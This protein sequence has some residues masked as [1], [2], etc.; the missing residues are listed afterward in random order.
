MFKF[1]RNDLYEILRKLFMLKISC[2]PSSSSLVSLLLLQIPPPPPS[3]LTSE[4]VQLQ[5]V[6]K[7]EVGASRLEA[8]RLCLTHLCPCHLTTN[9]LL[10]QTFTSSHTDPKICSLSCFGF[11][12]WRI[13]KKKKKTQNQSSLFLLPVPVTS[14][15]HWGERNSNENHTW[16]QHLIG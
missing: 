3:F 14:C 10:L 12:Y 8:S 16:L 5:Y 2:L 11:F 4:S 13:W 15:L 7:Q 6:G 9:T 1:I